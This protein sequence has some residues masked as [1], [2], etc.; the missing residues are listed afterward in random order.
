MAALVLVRV[1]SVRVEPGDARRALSFRLALPGAGAAA[2]QR[3][4]VCECVSGEL[5]WDAL[6]LCGTALSEAGLTALLGGGLVVEAFVG[7]SDDAPAAALCGT[8]AVSLAELLVSG[9]GRAS[10]RVALGQLGSGLLALDVDLELTTDAATRRFCSGSRV[11]SFHSGGSIRDVPEE[12][13]AA[14]KGRGRVQLEVQGYVTV[15]GACD[16]VAGQPGAVQWAGDAECRSLFLA[17]DSV[18]QLLAS[19]GRALSARCVFPPAAAPPAPETSAAPGAKK[20]AKAVAET[21]APP[22]PFDNVAEGTVDLLSLLSEGRTEGDAVIRLGI[23]ASGG[24]GMGSAS[25]AVDS[26]PLSARPLLAQ[27]KCSIIPALM[28]ARPRPPVALRTPHQVI[29]KLPARKIRTMSGEEMLQRAVSA[30]AD[31]VADEFVKQLLAVPSAEEGAM[32]GSPKHQRSAQLHEPKSMASSA[33]ASASPAP[34]TSPAET[35]LMAQRARVFFSLN[36][37]GAYAQMREQLKQAVSKL[38]SERKAE[39]RVGVV[40]SEDSVLY[41]RVYEYAMQL[42]H[43]ALNAKLESAMRGRVDFASPSAEQ[44]A[45]ELKV[46]QAQRVA[47]AEDAEILGDMARAE[48]LL[49]ERIGAAEQAVAAASDRDVPI[50]PAVWYR[51][52]VLCLRRGPEFHAVG[53]ECLR[54]AISISEKHVA[55]LV[56]Y[57]ALLTEQ[58]SDDSEQVETLLHA[59]VVAAQ[60]AGTDSASAAVGRNVGRRRS[61]EMLALSLLA[62]LR[63]RVAQSRYPSAI[64]VLQRWGVQLSAEGRCGD[65]ERVEEEEGGGVGHQQKQDTLDEVVAREARKRRRAATRARVERAAEALMLT[66][67][68]ELCLQWKLTRTAARLLERRAE[69]L[70]ACT[71]TDAEARAAQGATKLLQSWLALQCDDLVAAQDLAQQA[72]GALGRDDADAQVLTGLVAIAAGEAQEAK[73]AFCA[74]LAALQQHHQQHSQQLECGHGEWRARCSTLMH[75]TALMHLGN[76]LLGEGA[77]EPARAVFAFLCKRWPTAMTWV[78]LGVAS[79]HAGAQHLDAA[80]EALSEANEM[81]RRNPETWGFL[82]LAC[83]YQADSRAPQRAALERLSQQAFERAGELGLNS[84]PLLQELGVAYMNAGKLASAHRA[85][86]A[87]VK[88]EAAPEARFELARLLL[89]RNRFEEAGAIAQDLRAEIHVEDASRQQVDALIG[90]LHKYAPARRCTPVPHS[91]I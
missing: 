77:F 87:A 53:A 72:L 66:R 27:L 19:R 38:V 73:G 44:V 24:A 42:A 84:G 48:E 85:L 83:Q 62:T 12:C 45:R 81:D 41:S 25:P 34:S 21:P 6:G 2:A 28:A 11:L 49:V 18:E 51:Y 50:E 37:S 26:S 91:S 29:A 56:A 8:A 40:A 5:D 1:C 74:A 80:I 15:S 75:R 65:E 68:S 43:R 88:A 7:G 31:R 9:Y 17:R 4:A 90:L 79:M 20:G 78:G 33:S 3:S 57:A 23:V 59:A 14:C 71:Q 35:A 10:A 13:V 61:S 54:T 69:A 63:S 64:E 89:L 46:S 67:A 82:A 76:D 32:L 36:T 47:C 52:G 16:V 86:E 22:K 60:D 30:L 70:T 55:S 39:L 58:G